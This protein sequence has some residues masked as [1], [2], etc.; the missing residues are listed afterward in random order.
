MG[1]L[2][3]FKCVP[4]WIWA[5]GILAFLSTTVFAAWRFRAPAKIV[6][7]PKVDPYLIFHVYDMHGR[8]LEDAYLYGATEEFPRQKVY[9]DLSHKTLPIGAHR[10]LTVEYK[11]EKRSVEVIW[12]DPEEQK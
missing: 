4:R 9:G 5:V 2:F 10:S 3:C 6:V 11:G 8:P 1:D 12:R 7:V